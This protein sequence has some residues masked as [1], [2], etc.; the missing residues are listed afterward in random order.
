MRRMVLI[1]PHEI[2]IEVGDDMTWEPTQHQTIP[3][4]SGYY[5]VVHLSL[6]ACR[7]SLVNRQDSCGVGGDLSIMHACISYYIFMP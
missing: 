3:L 6:V 1:Q 7:L 5:N 4:L 2:A